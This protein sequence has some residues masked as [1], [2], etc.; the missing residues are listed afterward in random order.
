M[1]GVV[2]QSVLDIVRRDAVRHLERR[3][4]GVSH[5]CGHQLVVRLTRLAASS[6]LLLLIHVGIENEVEG[7]LVVGSRRHQSRAL[8]TLVVVIRNEGERS[9]GSSL[10]DSTVQHRWSRSSR[11]STTA[12][13]I[14]DGKS[15]I[16][17]L[18]SVRVCQVKPRRFFGLLGRSY[19]TATRNCCHCYATDSAATVKLRSSE[20]SCALAV[21]VRVSRYVLCSMMY[22]G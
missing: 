6:S 10:I 7:N 2:V 4:A 19:L 18:I 1:G 17:S 12:R 5:R 3:R 16:D 15:L 8:P 21:V 9:T 22:G 14:T 20:Q 11:T 13:R